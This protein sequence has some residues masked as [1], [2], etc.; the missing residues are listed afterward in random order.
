MA[1]GVRRPRRLARRVGDLRGGVL[2]RRCARPGLAE[3]HLPARADHLRPRHRGAAATVAAVD[4]DRG[5]DLGPGLVRAR[6]RLRPRVAALDRQGGRRWLAAERAED[7][8]VPSR[9]RTRGVR[10]VPF[11]PRAGTPPRADLLL[12]PAGG[13]RPDRAADRPARRRGRLRRAVL[14]RRLRARRRRA[15]GARRRLERRDEHRR[16]RARTVAALSR[17]LLRRGRPAARPV[18]RGPGA[19][20]SRPPSSMPG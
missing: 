9:V 7:L 18:R 4:G 19:G 8:V 1:R 5:E 20:H 13:R 2:P 3:R 6:G 12:L 16:Q 11:R 17:T 15:R 14:R 10:P